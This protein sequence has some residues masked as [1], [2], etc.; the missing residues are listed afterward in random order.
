MRVLSI[1]AKCSD[2]SV[3]ELYENEKRVAY[4][5]GYFPSSLGLGGGDYINID[6]NADTGQILNWMPIVK[7]DIEE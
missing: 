1:S 4:S 7:E 5:E 2:M 3:V 6:I